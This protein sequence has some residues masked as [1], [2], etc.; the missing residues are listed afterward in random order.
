M[1]LVSSWKNIGTHPL[2]NVRGMLVVECKVVGIPYRI[3]LSM[4]GMVAPD[5]RGYFI[6]PDLVPIPPKNVGINPIWAVQ[7]IKYDDA[8]TGDTYE[9]TFCMQWRGLKPSGEMDSTLL[10]VASEEEKRLKSKYE[11]FFRTIK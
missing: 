4:S 5:E 2:T 1:E 9:Q 3:P 7:F 11:E 10:N 6:T 8:I